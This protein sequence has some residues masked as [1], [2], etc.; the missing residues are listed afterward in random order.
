MERTRFLGNSAGVYKLQS[1]S[2]PER[3][4]IGS[5]VILIKRKREHFCKL[6]KNQHENPMLQN[7]VNK[8]G[9]TDLLFRVLEYCDKEECL[10]REQYYLDLLKPYFNISK[11]AASP[12]KGRKHSKDVVENMRKVAKQ[13]WQDPEYRRV[14]EEYRHSKSTL[15]SMRISHVGKKQ[16]KEEVE[17][18]KIR[19]K[20]LWE[21]PEYRRKHVEGLRRWFIQQHLSKLLNEQKIA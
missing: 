2:Y 20:K 19:V 12:M 13:L 18:K 5:G 1:K 7:H 11:F 8:Y 10:I 9:V 17:R 14:H 4:Y 6:K 3:I 15:E 21:D 16:S